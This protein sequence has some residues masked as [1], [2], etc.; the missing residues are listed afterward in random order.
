VGES[1]QSQPPC[2]PERSRKSAKAEFM[3][4]RRIPDYQ[5]LCDGVQAFSPRRLSLTETSLLSRGYTTAESWATRL[6]E[7]EGGHVVNVKTFGAVG[8]GATDD[9]IAIQNAI[10][11]A[12]SKKAAVFF[13]HG[14][15]RIPLL[16]T[17]SG[18]LFLFGYGDATLIGNFKYSDTNFPISADTS[19]PPT[20]DDPFFSAQGL[21]FKTVNG[22]YALTVA[23]QVQAKFITTAEIKNCRFYGKYGLQTQNLI[24]FHLDSCLFHNTNTGWRAEGC[25]NGS[26]IAC[27]WHNQASYGVFIT[28]FPSSTREGGENIRFSNCEWAV[29]SYGLYVER[30]W[31]LTLDNCLLDYC[32]VP[33]FLRGSRFAKAV[34][35]YFG[36]ADTPGNTF[37]T[38]IF[39][40]GIS[41]YGI[42]YADSP[43]ASSVRPVGGSFQNC[44]FVTY[45]GN[46]KRQEPTVY[47]EGS[48]SV[49]YAQSSWNTQPQAEKIQ[50]NNCLLWMPDDHKAETLLQISN[51]NVVG[52]FNNRFWAE[53]NTEG[54]IKA[55]YRFHKCTSARG[56]NNDFSLCLN[57]GGIVGSPHQFLGIEW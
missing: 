32:G 20:E 42:P 39:P 38:N 1:D 4:S 35:T 40:V 48:A 31:W 5:V 2:H 52:V 25:T 14:K 28:S 16:T 15:Y 22:D 50:L 24:T 43:E 55:T 33:L 13:P 44:E 26:V 57:A 10:T 23:A 56:A 30:H 46:K 36:A 7:K 3:R 6:G 9:S 53:I 34:S 21:N 54:T 19:S 11:K 12:Q 8:D 37:G 51:A 29:C 47:F 41:V 45:K 17:Q 27:K 18:R 49:A